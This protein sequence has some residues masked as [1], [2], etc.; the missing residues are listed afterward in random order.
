MNL[1][2]MDK[3]RTLLKFYCK[4]GRLPQK[5]QILAK[6]L[7]SIDTVRYKEFTYLLN[8]ICYSWTFTGC[9][10]FRR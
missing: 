6:L 2:F 7:N 4:I 5:R 1:A 3:I 10:Y 9:A 8:F